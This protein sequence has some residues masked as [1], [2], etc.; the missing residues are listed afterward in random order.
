MGQNPNSPPSSGNKQQ[1]QTVSGIGDIMFSGS[2]YITPDFRNE[3][4]YRITGSLKLGTADENKS[5][6]T[7]ED[8]LLF[9]GGIIKN[10]DE[11]ILSATLGYEI[12]GDS[13]VFVYNDIFYGTVGLSKQLAMSRRIGSYLYFSQAITDTSDSPLE[14]S[15]FYSQPVAKTRSIY[16]FLSKG[17]SDASPDFSVG[18][19]I[20]FYY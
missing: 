15:I 5:L 4:T 19:R 20:Q 12:S 11:Y 18:G 7:G 8:D 3:I 10:I 9:E 16:L 14:L 1:T 17:F 13:P 6:G 2:Y